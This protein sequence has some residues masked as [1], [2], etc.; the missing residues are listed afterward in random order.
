VFCASVAGLEGYDPAG[1]GTVLDI[2]NGL[3]GSRDE[4]AAR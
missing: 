1:C 4:L 2:A 3:R